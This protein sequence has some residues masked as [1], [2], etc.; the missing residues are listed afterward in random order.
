MKKLIVILFFIPLGLLA[1]DMSNEKLQTIYKSF[2]D[3]I[4]GNLG[5]WKFFIKE[6][7]MM[8]ITD[9]N[10]NRMRIISPIADASNLNDELIKAALVANFHTA[11]DVKYAVSD[12]VL[13]SVFI[14][15]LKELTAHQVKDALSQVYYANINFGT[16]FASTSLN[17]PGKLGKQRLEEKKED[18][19]PKYK[20]L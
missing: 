14:H 8:S 11:L 15:P 7:P 3:S 9:T 4:S 19:T 18:L 6:I 17:F 10:H 1:Q 5:G 20:K 12:G 13:W 2:S 16:T